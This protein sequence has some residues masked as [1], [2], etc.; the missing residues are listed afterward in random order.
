MRIVETHRVSLALGARLL[1]GRQL[2]DFIRVHGRERRIQFGQPLLR[3][4]LQAGATLHT[5]LVDP[6]VSNKVTG[7]VLL[8][9]DA[10]LGT[11]LR[12]P[13][14]PRQPPFWA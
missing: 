14:S 13:A 7:E 5:G 10:L 12:S 9:I 11:A 4:Y 1:D 2:S 3:P 6:Q 8:G